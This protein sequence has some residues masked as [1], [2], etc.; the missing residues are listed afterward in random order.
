MS[1][2]GLAMAGNDLGFLWD[3]QPNQF[4]W[5]NLST[6]NS[7][8]DKSVGQNQISPSDGGQNGNYKKGGRTAGEGP[9]SNRK[10]G[11]G[12]VC[13]K[14]NS[15]F[16]ASNNNNSSD[17]GGDDKKVGDSDHEIHIWTERERRKKM[18]N[19]F[20]NLHALLPQLPSKVI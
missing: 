1:D 15:S 11:K 20:A 5:A 16:I 6:E 8:E 13:K 3:D 14:K 18:R 9:T 17:V 12:G 2:I 7:E 10:R 19:M 4:S